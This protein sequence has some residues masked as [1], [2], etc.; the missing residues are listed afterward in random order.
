MVQTRPLLATSLWVIMSLILLIILLVLA[1]RPTLIT[2]ADLLAKIREQG[3]VSKQLEDKM[4]SVQTAT[5]NLKKID[6]KLYLLD[7]G[8]PKEDLWDQLASKLES[9]ATASGL[10][11]QNIII[12]KV[13]LS[14]TELI[15]TKEQP[16]I[17]SAPKGIIPIR[18]KIIAVGSYDQSRKLIEAVEKMRR[19]TIIDQANIDLTKE[20]DYMVTIQA[21][22]GYLPDKFIL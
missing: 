5:A 1:L 16:I 18:F 14:P 15:G 2:I 17:V 22:T 12:Y 7:V 9:I 6:D 3:E 4:V 10:K 11:I 21:E 13:P 8:L 20:G 19:I